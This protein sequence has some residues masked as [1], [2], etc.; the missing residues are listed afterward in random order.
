MLLSCF[1]WL[2]WLS[3]L[4]VLCVFSSAQRCCVN[5]E[6]HPGFHS[7][8]RRSPTLWQI[9]QSCTAHWPS[10][11]SQHPLC[12]RCLWGQHG[13]AYV[14]SSECCLWHS[15][16]VLMMLSMS[17]LLRTVHVFLI[18]WMVSVYGFTSGN[19]VEIGE[20]GGFCCSVFL[21]NWPVC[22]TTSISWSSV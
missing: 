7:N 12:A 17:T 9:P 18:K 3:W 16:L 1:L 15:W 2:L 14:S 19:W 10:H 6:S 4:T 20:E 21:E 22:W 13:H 5:G 8:G 11:W